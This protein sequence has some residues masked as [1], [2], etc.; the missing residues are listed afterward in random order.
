MPDVERIPIEF[1]KAVDY[2]AVA[3][4]TLYFGLYGA[5]YVGLALRRVATVLFDNLPSIV[6]DLR[7]E[8]NDLAE[9]AQFVA[10]GAEMNVYAA[11]DYLELLGSLSEI[12]DEDEGEEEGITDERI[13]ELLDEVF[14]ELR[15]AEDL[16]SEIE[17]VLY[18]DQL[19]ALLY[20]LQVVGEDGPVGAAGDDIFYTPA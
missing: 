16:D 5:A 13:G 15:L 4:E 3:E 18:E 2:V 11:L 8:F 9:E 20:S 7:Y 19:D 6:A 1:A 17:E 12:E 14:E 10:E